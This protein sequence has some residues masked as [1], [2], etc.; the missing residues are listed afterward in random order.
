MS[1]ETQVMRT[2]ALTS[3]MTIGLFCE[4]KSCTP[5]RN[6]STLI[7][8]CRQSQSLTHENGYLGS[9]V[10]FVLVNANYNYMLLLH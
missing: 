4:M 3:M 5:S 10:E 9:A 1:A 6:Y 8:S 2:R 7:A